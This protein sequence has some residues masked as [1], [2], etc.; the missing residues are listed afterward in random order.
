MAPRG[1]AFNPF[2]Q[3]DALEILKYLIPDLSLAFS[4]FNTRV[5][6]CTTCNTYNNFSTSEQ[7]TPFLQQPRESTLP[8]SE[9]KIFGHW[10]SEIH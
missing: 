10:L 8:S 4:F 7:V 5:K 9:E 3:Q 1:S 6:I 2:N